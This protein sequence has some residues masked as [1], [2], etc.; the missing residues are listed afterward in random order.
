MHL[1]QSSLPSIT[2][3]L[4]WLLHK[5]VHRSSSKQQPGN[6]CDG[7]QGILG[8][9]VLY[10]SS[11]V[12]CCHGETF[13]TFL[14]PNPILK[15][16]N[17]YMLILVAKNGSVLSTSISKLHCCSKKLQFSEHLALHDILPLLAASCR[18]KVQVEHG[19]RG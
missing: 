12:C 19:A 2:S 8:I 6:V 5:A 11:E 10:S 16:T 18:W 4:F 17:T 7:V 1:G 15:G 9:I 3:S 14:L 13:T